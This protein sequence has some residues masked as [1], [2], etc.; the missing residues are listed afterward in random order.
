MRKLLLVILSALLCLSS[1]QKRPEYISRDIYAMSTVIS[2]SI[3]ENT[4]NSDAL[5]KK[6]EE[7]IYSLES[8]LSATDKKS[9]ISR[10]NQSSE[11]TKLSKD[12]LKVISTALDVAK[13][14]N[15]AYDPTCLYLTEL[16]N[17]SEGGYLPTEDELSEALK[18]TDHSLLRID[19]DTLKKESTDIRIDLGGVAKGY[20][21]ERTVELLKKD[22]NFGMVSFGGN[23]GVWGD[24]PDSSK[25]E[26][27]IKDPFNTNE[28]IGFFKVDEGYISVSGDYE[29]YFEKD[30][31]RYHHIFDPETGHPVDNGIHSVAVYTKDGALG[32]A[33][34]TALFVMGYE[35][36]IELYESEIY[37]FEALFVTDDGIFMTDGAKRLF[38]EK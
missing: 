27:G 3:P 30:G 2:V 33:L 37:D 18:K 28:V 1:C 8:L 32:D 29:R 36:A 21:L 10:F 35:D 23:V 34:S 26:I 4:K 16:W 22:C 17:I 11:G 38:T 7:L 19:K 31:V 5:I 9:E 24:K 20:A 12:T 13:N 15:G 25:W 6:A 14:T